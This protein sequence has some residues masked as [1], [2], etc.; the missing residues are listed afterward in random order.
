MK[1]AESWS[2]GPVTRTFFVRRRRMLDV[3][4]QALSARLERGARHICNT[5]HAVNA[6]QL[7][8]TWART[9]YLA[10]SLHA[11][12]D[13]F[14][15]S[16]ENRACGWC[17][18]QTSR[19]SPPQTGANLL[20]RRRSLTYRFAAVATDVRSAA[21]ALSA[22]GGKLIDDP[23]QTVVSTVSADSSRTWTSRQRI[24]VGWRRW[25]SARSTD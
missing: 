14:K 16:F 22:A 19:P 11:K 8:E 21:Q 2:R 6:D 18:G 5:G 23:D 25:E 9:I 7:H 3:L 20:R 4:V 12:W 17:S 24:A 1:L 15:H 10:G 13:E